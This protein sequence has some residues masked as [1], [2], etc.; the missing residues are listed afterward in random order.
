MATNLDN[1]LLLRNQEEEIERARSL[2]EQKN[3]AAQAEGVS[4]R[5]FLNTSSVIA[6]TVFAH[7]ESVNLAYDEAKQAV[8]GAKEAIRHAV[9]STF[10]IMLVCAV[11]KDL[12]D[13][14]SCTF[15]LCTAGTALNIIITGLLL[16]FRSWNWIKIFLTLG[17]L[18]KK[19]NKV[20]FNIIQSSLKWFWI[21]FAVVALAEFIPGI[22]IVPTWTIY[23]V[24][25][26]IKN[27]M[28]INRLR[29]ELARNEKWLIELSKAV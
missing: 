5:R 11:F 7:E 27:M 17:L 26:K 21:T 1:R 4:T 29:D 14:P 18:K 15:S 3:Q 12:T 13:V 23:V 28:L 6:N 25:I 22:N 9:F 20:I 2:Q 16:V 10:F 19:A 24:A 8:Q